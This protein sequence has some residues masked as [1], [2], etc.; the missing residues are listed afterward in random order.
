MPGQDGAPRL[1]ERGVDSLEQ[2]PVIASGDHGSSSTVPVISAISEPGLRNA[3]PAQTP[4]PSRRRPGHVTAA[5]SATAR[6]PAGTTR[7]LRRTGRQ[8]VDQ[9]CAEPVGQQIGALGKVEMIPLRATLDLTDADIDGSSGSIP[10]CWTRVPE[11]EG[12]RPIARREGHDQPGSL[13]PGHP[14]TT[15]EA[16]HSDSERQN[17]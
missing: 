12:E 2:R 6:R 15:R 9:Q 17:P 13:L 16:E 10:R 1:I 5:G 14:A 8:R 7:A 3:T 4:S 11:S